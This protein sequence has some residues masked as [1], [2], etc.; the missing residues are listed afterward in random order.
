[1]L[2]VDIHTLQV[3]LAESAQNGGDWVPPTPM[4]KPEEAICYPNSWPQCSLCQTHKSQLTCTSHTPYFMFKCLKWTSRTA[5]ATK[6]SPVLFSNPLAYDLCHLCVLRCITLSH[7]Y[8]CLDI[9]PMWVGM[10][11]LTHIVCESNPMYALN[12]DIRFARTQYWCL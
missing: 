7:K 4:G 9:A 5:F 11:C 10:A 8:Q 6:W 3:V 1:M 2:V 12:R